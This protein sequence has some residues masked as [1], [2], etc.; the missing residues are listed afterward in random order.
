MEKAFFYIITIIVL[1]GCVAEKKEIK[2]EDVAIGF[3]DAIYN[4][5]DIEKAASFCSPAFSKE[6]KKYITANNAARRLFNMS[7][8]TVNIETG[9]GDTS[10]RRAF[11]DSGE[12]TILFTGTRDGKTFKD[13]KKIKLIKQKDYWYVDQILKDPTFG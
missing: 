3:F 1:T 12:L 13:L 7:F 2:A 5:K 10:V 8:D 9:L 11:S 6:L 4:Q